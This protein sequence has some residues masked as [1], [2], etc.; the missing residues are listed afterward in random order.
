MISVSPNGKGIDD[1]FIFSIF[2]II[3]CTELSFLISNNIGIRV[4]QLWQLPKCKTAV[5]NISKILVHTLIDFL[6]EHCIIETT[7]I[8]V[9]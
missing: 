8:G 1:D 5:I 9:C 2:L 4:T 7:L 3:Y 6:A